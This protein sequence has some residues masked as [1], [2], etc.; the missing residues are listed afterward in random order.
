MQLLA[1]PRFEDIEIEYEDPNDMYRFLGYGFSTFEYDGSDI[2]WCLG[3]LNDQEI[4]ESGLMEKMVR[5]GV[6]TPM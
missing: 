4:P 2:S 5:T 6:D 1:N 3:S